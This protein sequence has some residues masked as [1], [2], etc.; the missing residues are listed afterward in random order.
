[1]GTITESSKSGSV[2]TADALESK[3]EPKKEVEYEFGGPAGT[4]AVIA[5]LPLVVLLL[6]YWSRI[7]HVD[8]SILYPIFFDRKVPFWESVWSSPVLCPKCRGE[9]QIAAVEIW[10][11]TL[12]LPVIVWCMLTLIGWFLLQMSLERLL[13]CELVL[14]APIQ[15]HPDKFRLTYRINGHLAFW[16]T[17]LLFAVGW[18]VHVH[19][20]GGAEGLW[21]LQGFPYWSLLYEHF[22]ELGLASILLCFALSAY[23][24]LDSF[25]NNHLKS[26]SGLSIVDGKV[27]AVGGN[28][29][30]H[31]YEFFIGRELNPRL[32]RSTFDWKE[33]CELRPGM[34]GWVLLN[35]ASAH[36]QYKV[37][38]SIS[39]S[40]YLIN[41]FHGVYVWD[42]LYQ[43]KAILST[44]D[45]TTD[46]FG[47]MLVFGDL[48][49]VPFTYS[50]QARYLVHND[51]HLSW[52]QLLLILAF[53]MVGYV[54][55]RSANGQKD[56]FR[57]DPTDPS[58]AH[59]SYLPTKRGTKLL[60]S[61]WWGMARKINYTGDYI[62]GLSWCLVCGFGSIVPYYYA[63]YFL[64]LLVH[65]SIRDDHMCHKKYGDD[66]IAYKK[67]VPYR[68]VPAVV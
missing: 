3:Q 28:T 61:G 1:M 2:A 13:P 30:S 19:Q 56:T 11:T 7:G 59:L 8:L 35:A 9:H 16:F 6:A 31:I 33:F 63:I 26:A 60:T 42:A 68:F 44:M 67:L 53:H 25:S 39:G 14:G 43:E 27:L 66:W 49:W 46:G 40:M 5:L 50:L 36:E 38:G 21:Q 20:S 17:L 58:V 52:W 23:L 51:P 24:Y 55:F 22:A 54:I 45:I 15:Q 10:G 48:C 32:W 29:G 41:I 65:R 18:P 62:M 47:F 57:R 4:A 64:I 12:Q 34:I 37:H